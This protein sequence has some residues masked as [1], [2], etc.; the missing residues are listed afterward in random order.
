MFSAKNMPPL[1]AMR[2]LYMP[3]WSRLTSIR[4]PSLRYISAVS[5]SFMRS[6]LV[7][8]PSCIIDQESSSAVVL[9][10]DDL[11]VGSL[12]LVAVLERGDGVELAVAAHYVLG[13][14][15]VLG[16]GGWCQDQNSMLLI[17]IMSATPQST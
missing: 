16:Q 17:T 15:D 12:H 14:A 13:L 3:C 8:L 1:T 4:P 7:V 2:A 5:L 11:A 6:S 9:E 10:V